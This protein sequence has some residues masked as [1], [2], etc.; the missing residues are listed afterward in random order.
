MSILV[1]LSAFVNATNVC[2]VVRVSS[3][4]R[5]RHSYASWSYG[6]TRGISALPTAKDPTIW[7]RECKPP[8][9]CTAA[10]P[11]TQGS[12]QCWTSSSSRWCYSL[13]ESKTNTAITEERLFGRR[14]LNWLE[15]V[16]LPRLLSTES[17]ELSVQMRVSLPSL[18]RC[19]VTGITVATQTYESRYLVQAYE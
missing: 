8:T 11:K 13:P 2:F 10:H 4:V 16:G 1:D 5:S 19:D 12:K 17:M 3:S 7:H 15:L 18:T 14:Y 6:A 9:N